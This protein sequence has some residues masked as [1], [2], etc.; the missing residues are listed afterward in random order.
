MHVLELPEYTNGEIEPPEEC[1]DNDYVYYSLNNSGYE[2]LEKRQHDAWLFWF[3]YIVT[4]II[5]AS[6]VIL[7]IANFICKH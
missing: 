3:P 5:A 4:T 7:Q 1:F 2:H 6:S